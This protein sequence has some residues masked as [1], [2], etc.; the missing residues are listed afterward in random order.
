MLIGF[1]SGKLFELP[2]V[3][4]ENLFI[5]IGLSALLLFIIIRYINIYGDSGKWSVQKNAVY[6]FLSFINITKYPPSFLFCL[7]TSGIMFL[8]LAFAD[9]AKTKF[10]RIVSAYGKVPLFYFLIHFFLIHFIMLAVMFLQGFK[11]SQ[12]DFASGNFGRPKAVESGLPLWAIYFVWIG[13][14]VVLYKP[15]KWYGKYK[16]LHQKWWLK[17]M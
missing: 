5:K 9:K 2:E 16:S 10:S 11:W 1:A 8:I 14:V 4:R 6:T 7:A 12:L 13:V 3:K 15:C 17:Y